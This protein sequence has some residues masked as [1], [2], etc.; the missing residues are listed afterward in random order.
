MQRT[1]FDFNYLIGLCNF[2]VNLI[3]IWGYFKLN[4]FDWSTLNFNAATGRVSF[5]IVSNQFFYV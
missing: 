3:P 5:W 2:N 4:C 1:N